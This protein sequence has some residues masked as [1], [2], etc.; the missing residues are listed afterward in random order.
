M[1]WMLH[2]DPLVHSWLLAKFSGAV[3]YILL[4]SIAIRHGRTKQLRA[5]AFVGAVSVFAYIVGV[6]LTKSPLSWI[7]YFAA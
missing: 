5:I 7:R 1:L 4:G 3:A 6:A 2:L